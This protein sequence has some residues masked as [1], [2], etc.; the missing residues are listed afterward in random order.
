MAV[1]KPLVKKKLEHYKG[2]DLVDFREMKDGKVAKSYIMI[3]R[4]KKLQITQPFKTLQAA[5][6]F[7]D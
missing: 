3:C 7:I 2:F 6:D 4:G 5:K 1:K